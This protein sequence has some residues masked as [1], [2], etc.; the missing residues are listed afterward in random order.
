MFFRKIHKSKPLKTWSHSSV[1]NTP[2]LTSYREKYLATWMWLLTFLFQKPRALICSHEAPAPL[3]LSFPFGLHDTAEK[4]FCNYFDGYCSCDMIGDHSIQF[5]FSLKKL[6]KIII[7]DVWTKQMF[8]FTS[9]FCYNPYFFTHT[10]HFLCF[11]SLSVIMILVIFFF[12]NCAALISTRV[13]S[14][15]AGICISEVQRW[16][17]MFRSGSQS[18]CSFV[19]KVSGGVEVR[20]NTMMGLTLCTQT[21][22]QTVA[23]GLE[24][25][26]FLKYHFKGNLGPQ[27]KDSCMYAWNV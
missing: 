22:Y 19:P 1:Y 27:T 11:F 24:G 2:G 16:H 26:H 15:A 5:S 25:H 13:L 20:A 12:I 3:G 9:V 18:L 21:L 7:V 8:F 14:L 10:R 17:W 4:S 6:I 23:T